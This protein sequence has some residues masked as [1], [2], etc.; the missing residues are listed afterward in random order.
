MRGVTGFFLRAK[1]WQLFLVLVGLTSV[2]EVAGIVASVRSPTDI[3]PGPAVTILMTAGMLCFLG[4]FWALGSFLNSVVSPQLR[5]ARGF[6]RFAV[7][8]P[9]LYVPLF[10]VV[11]PFSNPSTFAIILPLHFLCMGCLLY[12]MYFV[13]KN[14]ALVE[15]ARKVRFYDYAGPFF[16]L[17]FFPIGIWIVQPRINRLYASRG[18]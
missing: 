6:F 12:A 17:W 18:Q 8:Y 13:S 15:T 5:P 3:R 4:W 1:H 7:V 14:L 10:L 11:F 16:L 9:A 2:A